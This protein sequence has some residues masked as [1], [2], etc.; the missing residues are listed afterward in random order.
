MATV[1]VTLNQPH[2]HAGKQYAA[3]SPLEVGMHD[4][5][6]LLRMKVIDKIPA[7]AGSA[8]PVENNTG[9]SKRNKSAD[10]GV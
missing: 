5:R 1:K 8:D 2:K 6:F 10:S 4:A 7:G 3:G 9:N